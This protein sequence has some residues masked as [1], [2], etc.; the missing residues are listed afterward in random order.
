MPIR[1]ATSVTNVVVNAVPTG[2][3]SNTG[4]YCD[5]D[6]IALSSG[7]GSSYSWTGPNGFAECFAKSRSE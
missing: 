6:N 3:I 2:N 1:T 5:G 4:P 7:G